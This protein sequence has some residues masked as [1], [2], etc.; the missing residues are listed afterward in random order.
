MALAGNSNEFDPADEL[1]AKVLEGIRDGARPFSW[2][3]PR[4]VPRV[5]AEQQ[6]EQRAS[7]EARQED[8][9]ARA[10][11]A[12]ADAAEATPADVNEM[13]NAALEGAVAAKAEAVGLMPPNP[14]TATA[15]D[16][17]R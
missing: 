10:E 13:F 7:V 11:A 12:Q 17:F 4:G 8:A 14:L 1:N 3:Q 16:R 6:A 15:A 5:S 2:G 9:R